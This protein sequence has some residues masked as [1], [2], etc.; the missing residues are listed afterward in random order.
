MANNIPSLRA[1]GKFVVDAPFTKVVSDTG[2][3]TVEAVRTIPEMQA[4]RPA[5]NLF[6]LIYAPLGY[7]KDKPEDVAEV[8]ALLETGISQNAAVVTL[9]SRGRGPVNVLSTY[10]KSF[11]LADG[12][13]Y[14]RLGIVLDLGPCPPA[15]KEQ[16]NNALVHFESYIK[17]AFGIEQPNATLGTVPIRGYVSK[18]TAT[19]WEK[20]RQNRIIDEP[21]DTII[22]EKQRQQIAELQTY[23]KKLEDT[24][25]NNP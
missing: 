18:E 16:V 15:M 25:K 4:I 23:V 3:Y 17:G 7:D 11:P 1:A 5:I 20:S 6:A 24:I 19:A 22:I 8:N 10:I 21:S 14:E 2:F 13:I 9:T 12:V